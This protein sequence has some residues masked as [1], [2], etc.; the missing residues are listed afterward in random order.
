[1]KLSTTLIVVAM[2]APMSLMAQEEA[3]SPWS[4]KASLGYLATTGNT[5][6]SSLNTAVEVGFATGE[7]QHI[8]NAA[9]ISSAENDINTAEAYEL[10]WKTERNLSDVSFLFGRLDWRKDVFGAFDTQFSQSVGYGYRLIKTDKHQL[11]LEAGVGARQSETQIGVKED[12]MIFRGGAYYTFLFSET[13]EFRQDVTAEAGSDNTYM[14][15]I[16]AVSAKLLGDLALVASFTVKYNT[17]VPPL[18]EKTDT[19][20]ALSLEYA[21]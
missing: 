6:N 9:A 15:S 21:F 20:S 13:A 16:T 17:D 14:E 4:G 1:M 3:E 11:N 19:Y 12:E 2:L 7:W 10:G 18:T 8:A 5:E